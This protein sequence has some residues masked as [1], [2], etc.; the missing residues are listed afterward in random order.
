MKKIRT[1]APSFFSFAPSHQ[2][3]NGLLSLTLSLQC[4][5]R[6]W[7]TG[8]ENHRLER[9]KLGARMSLSSRHSLS[10]VPCHRDGQL[11]GIGT[12]TA[13]AG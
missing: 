1:L 5:T 6:P 13:S 7:T 8:S 2:E 12:F 10:P 9:Q 11:T 3:V 4:T